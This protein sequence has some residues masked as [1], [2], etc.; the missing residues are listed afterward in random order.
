M[1]WDNIRNIT[2]DATNFGVTDWQQ[3]KAGTLRGP[4]RLGFN[5]VIDIHQRRVE[6]C[7]CVIGLQ[8]MLSGYFFS[9]RWIAVS[10]LLFYGKTIA[11]Q[12]SVQ[13]VLQRYYDDVSTSR[14][15][16]DPFYARISAEVCSISRRAPAALP[17][18][19]RVL[20][21]APH[22]RCKALRSKMFRTR[23]EEHVAGVTREAAGTGA[24]A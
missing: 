3:R 14:N 20:S 4:I 2:K 12:G 13:D 1:V 17:N 24:D 5:H 15:G 8:E 19:I 6:N 22:S 23:F 18:Y 7:A 21:D 16:R 9:D 11:P 10:N